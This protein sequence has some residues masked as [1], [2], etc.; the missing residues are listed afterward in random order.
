MMALLVQ[1]L[2]VAD[3]LI[4]LT[5]QSLVPNESLS[6]PDF[7]VSMLCQLEFVARNRAPLRALESGGHR[8]LRVERDVFAGHGNLTFPAGAELLSPVEL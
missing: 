5:K 8:D 1:N 4:L 3:Q 6:Q 2:L 7:R